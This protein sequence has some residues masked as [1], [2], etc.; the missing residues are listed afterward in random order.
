MSSKAMLVF[1][2]ILKQ[3]KDINYVVR[4]GRSYL[5]KIPAPTLKVLNSVLPEFF[6][7]NDW[8]VSVSTTSESDQLKEIII[9]AYRRAKIPIKI[10][11]VQNEKVNKFLIE[12]TTKKPIQIGW[13]NDTS[14]SEVG[15]IDP[16]CDVCKCKGVKYSSLCDCFS[17]MHRALNSETFTKREKMSI[18]C[19]VLINLSKSKKLTPYATSLVKLLSEKLI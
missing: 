11:P 1:E 16:E 17:Q 5:N 10:T 2:D 3:S 15:K 14:L 6:T 7:N 18:R 19:R 9:Q 12:T 4:G 8:N 13:V